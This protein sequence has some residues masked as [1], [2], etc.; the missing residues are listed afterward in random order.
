MKAVS[1]RA[2]SCNDVLMSTKLTLA[3]TN[4]G[5]MMRSGFHITGLD[6][7]Q[8]KSTMVCGSLVAT[9]KV[10]TVSPS[11]L[12]IVKYVLAK[13]V[14]FNSPCSVGGMRC[15]QCKTAE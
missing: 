12:W 7:D 3:G 4:L 8:D 5:W 11:F 9:E 6:K 13:S 1:F 2:C 15:K 10:L 14:I